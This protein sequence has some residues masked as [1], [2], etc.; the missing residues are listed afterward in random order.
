MRAVS[1]DMKRNSS[2][3]LLNEHEVANLCAISVATLQKWRM[4]RSG[5]QF[6]KLGNRVRY[7]PSDVTAWL[8]CRTALPP[9][10]TEV[11]P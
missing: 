9:A 1:I 5:P 4:L 11:H 6:L 2:K 8:N 10:K 3:R 7:R